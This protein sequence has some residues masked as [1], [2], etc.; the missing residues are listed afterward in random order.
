MGRRLYDDEAVYRAAVDE[1]AEILAR[2]FGF[3]LLEI[4]FGTDEAALAETRIT[5]PAL[6]VT[7]Y[8]LARLWQSWGVAPSAMLGHSIGE[9]VAAH[10]AGVMTLEDALTVVAE[11]GRLMQ[12]M[13]PGTMLAVE[14]GSPS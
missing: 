2:H 14:L 13:A 6:F 12:S 10:L 9:Y 3:D 1:A 8:A 5:Q 11:R 4:L 7:E